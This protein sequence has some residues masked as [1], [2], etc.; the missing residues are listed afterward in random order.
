MFGVNVLV[1][2]RFISKLIFFNRIN[3][4]IWIYFILKCALFRASK[5]YFTILNY[6]GFR[7]NLFERNAYEYVV[8]IDLN[9][10]LL[11]RHEAAIILSI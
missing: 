5:L 9:Y 4:S 7:I 1:L 8:Y 3:L 10:Y 6:S 2:N 11:G